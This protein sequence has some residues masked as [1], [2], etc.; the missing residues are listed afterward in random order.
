LPARK[1]HIIKLSDNDVKNHM[2][3][4]SRNITSLVQ[5]QRYSAR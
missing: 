3:M 4:C 5:R 1:A 2:M